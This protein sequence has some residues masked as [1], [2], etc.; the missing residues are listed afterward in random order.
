MAMQQL[1]HAVSGDVATIRLSGVL[2]RDKVASLGTALRNLSTQEGFGTIRVEIDSPG[3]ESFAG[4]QHAAQGVLFVDTRKRV[5]FVVGSECRDGAYWL[6]SQSD[7]IIIRPDS[8]VGFEFSSD[9]SADD[10]R[11][12]LADIGVARPVVEEGYLTGHAA[13]DA[14]LADTLDA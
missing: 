12:M 7:E 10:R 11:N 2:S 9:V 3:C 1:S 14:G 8:V 5:Q 4:L 6:A 13:V